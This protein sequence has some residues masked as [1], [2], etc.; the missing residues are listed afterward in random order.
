SFSFMLMS[1]FVLYLDRKHLLNRLYAFYAL[2]ASIYCFAEFAYLQ[3]ASFDAAY[4]WLKARSAWVFV[5][6]L[7]LHFHLA[8]T[9]RFQ[10]LKNKLFMGLLYGFG[11]VLF[12]AD[13]FTDK[14]TGTPMWT[15]VIWVYNPP[16]D[17][18]LYYLGNGYALAAIFVM[19]GLTFSFL[20]KTNNTI[21]KRPTR[22]LL[23]ADII[24]VIVVLLNTFVVK[25]AFGAN[26][27]VD[28]VLHLLYNLVIVYAIGKFNLLQFS[29]ELAMNKVISSMPGFLVLVNPDGSINKT[30]P[31]ISKLTGYHKEDLENHSFEQRFPGLINPDVFPNF[32]EKLKNEQFSNIKGVIHHQN[33]EKVSVMYSVSAVSVEIGEQPGLIY[34]GCELTDQKRVERQLAQS[35]AELNQAYHSLQE[36]SQI[37]STELFQSL[38][39]MASYAELSRKDFSQGK[40]DSLNQYLNLILKEGNEMHEKLVGLAEYSTVESP[41][42]YENVS[43]REVMDKTLHSIKKRI[44]Q[45]QAEIVIGELPNLIADK[46]QLEVLFRNLICNALKFNQADNPQ[47]FIDAKLRKDSSWEFSVKDNGIGIDPE[48]QEKIFLPNYRIHSQDL[49]QGM[50]MG[51]SLCKQIIEKH[52][53]RIWVESEPGKG[54]GFYFTLPVNVGENIPVLDVQRLF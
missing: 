30:N 28:G 3:A 18:V 7:A 27:H 24:G 25:S 51:L 34:M 15:G 46:T 2:T 4:F 23:A 11:G 52:N 48:Y 33:G 43:V 35:T 49:Y 17:S 22:F 45:T 41:A 54:A 12:L 50:G 29:P 1:G 37:V 47:I 10:L 40:S 14:V 42:K 13:V 19:L 21:K 39:V 9:E 5:I 16:I 26:F 36:I 6:L 8:F 32:L 38:R 53:G 31:A 44:D 20:T